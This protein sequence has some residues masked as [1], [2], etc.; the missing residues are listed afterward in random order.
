MRRAAIVL[1][2]LG[3][4][5]AAVDG[6]AGDDDKP[7]A[8]R[9]YIDPETG[10]YTTEDPLTRLEPMPVVTAPQAP[11]SPVREGQTAAALLSAAVIVA[12]LV[13]GILI[14]RRRPGT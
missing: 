12:M 2:C 4:V 11:S 14:Y 1:F 6:H 3:A 5:L 8:Y 9:I 7:P 13:G 10:K